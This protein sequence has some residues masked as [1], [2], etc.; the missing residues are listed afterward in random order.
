MYVYSCVS[1]RIVSFGLAI[2]LS[3]ESYVSL[4]AT[5]ATHF[6]SNGLMCAV[7][8]RFFKIFCNCLHALYFILMQTWAKL[9]KVK[10][11]RRHAE[12]QRIRGL[13]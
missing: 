1:Y 5:G 2:V 11:P 4:V 9:G 13:A 8:A 10:K 7:Y 12:N 6:V 3:L